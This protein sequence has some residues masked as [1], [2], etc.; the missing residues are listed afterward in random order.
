M[1]SSSGSFAQADGSNSAS[2]TFETPNSEPIFSGSTDSLGND[3]LGSDGVAFYS[4][5]NTGAVAVALTL[6]ASIGYDSSSTSPPS[7]GTANG[8]DLPGGALYN[9]FVAIAD[10]SYLDGQLFGP[11]S[12][13]SESGLILSAA[14]RI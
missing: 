13:A 2:V 3:R 14:G 9:A 5:T 8:Q 10:P 6:S 12:A 7:T 11:S 4:Y 1:L